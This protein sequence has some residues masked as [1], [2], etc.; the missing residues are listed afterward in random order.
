M[1]AVSL[2]PLNDALV[3]ATARGEAA[4]FTALE[5]GR[6]AD[7]VLFELRLTLETLERALAERPYVLVDDRI[8]RDG[9]TLW[10]L[11]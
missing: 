3:L 1:G 5:A 4:A 8:E 2:S 11:D 10:I 7:P 6:S 9:G